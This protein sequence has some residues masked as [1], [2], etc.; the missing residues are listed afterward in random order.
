VDL[1]LRTIAAVWRL[2]RIP[3]TCWIAWLIDWDVAWMM[4]HGTSSFQPYSTLQPNLTGHGHLGS[5]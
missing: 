4:E 2:A 1:R 5:R 3:R